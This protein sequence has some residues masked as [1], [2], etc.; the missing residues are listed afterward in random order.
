MPP[1]WFPGEGY[2][3]NSYLFEGVLV[4]AGVSPLVLKRF[5]EEVELILLTHCHYDHTAYLAEI[6]HLTG[7]EIAIHHRDAPFI[8]DALRSASWIF[9]SMPPVK[10]AD[11][12]L[13]D[14]DV[15]HGM[16]VIHT[17]GHTQGS[18]CLYQR[19]EKILF[20]GDTVFT[21]GAFGRFDLPGGDV[22]ALSRS[23]ERI[24][25]LDVEGLYPGHGTPVERG[26]SWHI[27]LARRN[28][29]GSL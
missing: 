9:G 28:I 8:M 3:A 24:S 2:R 27:A 20:S 10:E 1:R 14:G 15:L 11:I 6:A 22:A 12:L 16:E 23:L 25:A 17:P 29:S 13:E 4:D 21:D 19:G 5:A 7:A 18:I 26:G